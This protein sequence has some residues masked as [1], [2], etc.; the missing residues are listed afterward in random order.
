MHT[1]LSSKAATSHHQPM[2]CE[3]RFG[4]GFKG[5]DADSCWRSIVDMEFE[6][7]IVDGDPVLDETGETEWCGGGWL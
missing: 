4:S 2:E 5:G 6:L 7:L 3:R 1:V